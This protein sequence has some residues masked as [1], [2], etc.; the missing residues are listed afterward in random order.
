[1]RISNL[2]IPRARQGVAGH[3][4]GMPCVRLSAM[5]GNYP[6]MEMIMSRA[7]PAGVADALEGLQWLHIM[8]VWKA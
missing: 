1:M 7:F 8:G 3:R 6:E 2:L 4:S 5:K